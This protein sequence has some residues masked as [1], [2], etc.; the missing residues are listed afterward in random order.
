[1]RS[2]ELSN[3]KL[4]LGEDLLN[5]PINDFL[6][7]VLSSKLH[8]SA[9][10]DNIKRA[11]V[12]DDE[13]AVKSAT[14]EIVDN[15]YLLILELLPLEVCDGGGHRLR[16]DAQDFQASDLARLHRRILLPVVEVGG[17][18][19]DAAGHNLIESLLRHPLDVAQQH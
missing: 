9:R 10:R 11:I 15:D 17:D 5:E 4:A 13:G 16:D 12:E 1:L 18:G 7:N 6:V 14:A 19:D 2:P 8:V 3:V